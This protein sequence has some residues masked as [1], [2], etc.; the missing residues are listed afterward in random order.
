MQTTRLDTNEVYVIDDF[1]STAYQD[2]LEKTFL[3]NRI[4]LRFENDIGH[5]DAR[6]IGNFGFGRTLRTDGADC[7]KWDLICLPMVYDAMYAIK[8]EVAWVRQGRVFMTTSGTPNKEDV[9]HVDTPTYHIV[10]L[11]YVHD[12]EGDTLLS[13]KIHDEHERLNDMPYSKFYENK[14]LGVYKSVTPKKGRVVIFNGLRY[15]CSTRPS[16]GY[17]TVINYNVI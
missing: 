3:S 8:R 5:A 1:I 14:S 11:Y 15:H 17:R 16:K 7:Q 12:S 2:L 4:D 10:V 9:Y 6:D 13:D